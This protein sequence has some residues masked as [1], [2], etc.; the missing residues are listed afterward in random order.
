MVD[1]WGSNWDKHRML[2]ADVGRKNEENLRDE[3]ELIRRVIKVVG[4][5]WVTYFHFEPL[6]APNGLAA[7]GGRGV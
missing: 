5:G 2:V 6:L 4:G 7:C 1:D 3:E